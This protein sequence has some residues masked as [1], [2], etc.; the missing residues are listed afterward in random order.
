MQARI[1]TPGFTAWSIKDGVHHVHPPAEI[2]EGML[3]VRI[4]LDD[5]GPDNGPLRV[6]SGTHR[7]GRLSDAQIAEAHNAHAEVV[8]TVKAGGA[9][10][11]RPLLV[12]ASSAA[13][14]PAHRRVLHID[15]AAADLPNGLRWLDL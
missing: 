13:R 9:V 3:A 8:C 1:D 12:H 6:L 5:C 15:F 10:L 7:R 11:M 2:L 4:H 14:T